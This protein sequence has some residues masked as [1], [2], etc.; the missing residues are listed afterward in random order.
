MPTITGK[1]QSIAVQVWEQ[2]LAGPAYSAAF[3][4]CKDSRDRI[5]VV[6]N[7]SMNWISRTMHPRIKSPR[8]MQ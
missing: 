2:T 7:V 3:S 6:T 4:T 1:V 5:D 8:K